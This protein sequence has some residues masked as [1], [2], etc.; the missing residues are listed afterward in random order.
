MRSVKLE[1]TEEEC[2]ILHEITTDRFWTIVKWFTEGRPRY[3]EKLAKTAERL[4]IPYECACLI[5]RHLDLLGALGQQLEDA[6][7][8]QQSEGEQS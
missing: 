1:V 8:E 5:D 3:V 2:D 4:G 7:Y 6:M